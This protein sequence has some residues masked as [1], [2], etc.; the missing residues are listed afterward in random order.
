MYDWR[1]DSYRS[2]EFYLRMMALAVGSRRFE[3]LPEMYFAESRGLI[4]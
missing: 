2:W 4:P 1:T 3:T